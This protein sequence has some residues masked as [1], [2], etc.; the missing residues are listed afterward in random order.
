MAAYLSQ[1]RAT[2]AAERFRVKDQEKQDVFRAIHEQAD[3]TR[4]N[5]ARSLGIRPSTVCAVVQELI[6]DRLVTEGRLK[7]AGTP[8]R[9]E[10]LLSADT[11]RFVAIA[12]SIDSRD[13]AG[14]LVGMGEQVIAEQTLSIPEEA[15]SAFFLARCGEIIAGLKARSPKGSELL[16][17]GLS[18]VGTVDPSRRRWIS[19]ARWP[20]IRDV[21][22]AGLEK[23]QGVRITLSRL[24]DSELEYQLTKRPHLGHAN[25]LLFHW[26]FGIGSAYAHQGVV[27]DSTI[28]RFGEVGHILA[29]A[30]STKRC[31][32][33]ALGCLETEAALWAI[34]PAI[35][36]A[37]PA[38]P[39][40]ERG[41]TAFLAAHP[42]VLR[43]PAVTRALDQVR[44]ALLTLHKLFY[45]NCTLLIGPFTEAAAVGDELRRHLVRSLPAYAAGAVQIEVIAEGSAGCMFGSTYPF[46]RE[47][48]SQALRSRF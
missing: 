18:L 39:R 26:G 22:F 31:L 1:A 3:A 19:S 10:L 20:N 40:E 42:S 27:L 24:L 47:R 30:R 11:S 46:F 21:T 16:G 35:G 8:G 41:F 15:D 48:L 6:D 32:C 43:L 29:D 7:N 38:A 37:F 28:G 5:L 17:V 33:G 23:S 12:L 36:K 14:A 34:L 25:V 4:K 9:P 13:L 2:A 44:N 45:P